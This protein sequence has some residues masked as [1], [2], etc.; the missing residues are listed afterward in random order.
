MHGVLTGVWQS[1]ERWEAASCSFRQ[2]MVTL[3][4]HSSH[5]ADTVEALPHVLSAH[6]SS[7]PAVALL[8]MMT[9]SHCQCLHLSASLP[10][11]FLWH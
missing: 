10:E 4:C 9:A 11:D 1:W 8:C 3:A 2:G 6:L 7:P 5:G